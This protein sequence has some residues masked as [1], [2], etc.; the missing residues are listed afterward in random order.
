M[1]R[2]VLFLMC[3]VLL[4]G[5]CVPLASAQDRRRSR[6]GRK[7][8]TAAIIGGGAVAGALLGGK[9]GA[10][11]GAGGGTLYAMNRKAA[12]RHFKPGTRRL[13]TV[14]GGGLAGAGLGA[15]IGHGKGAAIGGLAGAAGS[16]IYTKKSR[17]YRRPY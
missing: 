7:S 5:V 9:K 2:L 14:A 10:A 16:Y 8:R 12:R 15:A 6:F 4:A 3:L 13:G 1:K 11:I 17:H